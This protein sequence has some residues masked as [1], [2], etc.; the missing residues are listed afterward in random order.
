VIKKESH[1]KFVLLHCTAT[2]FCF[3][4]IVHVIQLGVYEHCFAAIISSS[5]YDA[6]KNG[7]DTVDSPPLP[8]ISTVLYAVHIN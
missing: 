3:Y 2:A 1:G 5:L 4:G 7:L 8:L 6:M